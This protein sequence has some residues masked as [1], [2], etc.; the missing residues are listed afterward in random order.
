MNKVAEHFL[1]IWMFE[2]SEQGYA[3]ILERVLTPEL[4]VSAVLGACL[5]YAAIRFNRSEDL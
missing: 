4:V 5:V 3:G 1:P 2:T